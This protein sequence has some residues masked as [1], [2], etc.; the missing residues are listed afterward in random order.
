MHSLLRPKSRKGKGR[1][2]SRSP[3]ATTSLIT[4]EQEDMKH[5]LHLVFPEKPMLDV[6]FDN[7]ASDDLLTTIK[8]VGAVWH[9]EDSAPEGTYKIKANDVWY[10][11]EYINDE[12][13][14]T[15]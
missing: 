2:P 9:E 7:R 11:I 5:S 3:E 8:G 10:S 4:A 13:Y 6:Y 14:Y 12:W 1:E 15:Y